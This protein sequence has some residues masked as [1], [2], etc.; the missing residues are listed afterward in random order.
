MTLPRVLVLHNLPG[1]GSA[2]AES[3][4]GV[5]QEAAAV[6]DAL[7]ALGVPCRVAGVR[8]PADVPVAVAAGDEAV[9]FNLVEGFRDR[10]EDANFVP[11]VC[12]SLGRAVT[13][14]GTACLS[15]AL[16]KWRSKAVL[17]AAGL[18]VPPGACVPPGARIARGDLP[19][20]P[21]I[22]KPCAADAS[23]GI[24]AASSVVPRSGRGLRAAV[25]RVHER[26]GQ[27]ALVERF[28]D[29]REINVSVIQ[30]GRAL[31]VLA[32]AEI[33]FVDFGRGRPRIV[34]YAA[35]WRPE[36]FEYAHTR[37]A[38]PARLPARVAA[39]VRKLAV[40]AARAI[41]CADYAR[42]DFRLDRRLRPFILEVNPN[43]DIAPDA[44]FTAAVAHAG[45]RYRDFVRNCVVNA[46]ACL[47]VARPRARRAG[48]A[49]EVLIR[50][51]RAEDRAAILAFIEA[52]GFFLPN[53]VAVAGGVLDSALGAGHGGHYQSFTAAVGG[54]PVGWVC[55]GRTPCT[56]GTFDLYWIAVAPE[57]QR[58][59]IGRML[60]AF[61]ERLM[62]EHGGRLAVVETAGKPA[63]E[64]TRAFYLRCGYEIAARLRDF[65]DTGD[66]KVVLVKRL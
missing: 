2:C 24:D 66:D 35:K 34:D 9:V 39:E 7:K 52:T 49:G 14:S 30:R 12:R 10:S 18:P 44:G 15:L 59:G 8:T 51:T 23:E 19:P 6:A 25:R 20:P 29:G 13:G 46:A 4:A 33:E 43:P 60:V 27:A 45:W 36:S 65:Y 26:F 22:V 3:E 40:A 64:S 31:E 55:Y 47:P 37:R 11:A 16:D 1:G 58:H 63:Y 41:G 17:A 5:L 56:A 61:A 28:I 50:A 53:E 57:R 38:L 62:A 54:R 32:I 42:V 21:C 48:P